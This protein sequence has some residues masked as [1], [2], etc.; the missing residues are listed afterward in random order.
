MSSAKTK[1]VLVFIGRRGSR[2][3]IGSSWFCIQVMSN[4]GSGVFGMTPEVQESVE[5]AVTAFG[6]EKALRC[7]A[8]AYKNHSGS[9]SKA[10]PLGSP[11]P[12]L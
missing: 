10:S 9:S 8:L 3:N 12:L 2:I 4:D 6:S 7:L 5:A 11:A 1:G